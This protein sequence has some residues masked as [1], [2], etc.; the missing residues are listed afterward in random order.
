[1]KPG[2]KDQVTITP[3]EL[4]K[5]ALSFPE[6]EEGPPVPAAGR[7][8]AFKVAGKSFLG[9]EKGGVTVTLSLAE[10]DARAIATTNRHAHEEIWRN[11]KFLGLWLDLSRVSSRELRKMIELSWRHSAPKRIAAEFGEK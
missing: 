4:R 2:A 8:L 3:D 7:V 6:V 9:L 10:G 11:G 5:I 1:M